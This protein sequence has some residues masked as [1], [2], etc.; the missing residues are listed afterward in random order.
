MPNRNI[1][2]TIVAAAVVVI[3]LVIGANAHFFKGQANTIATVPL[4][5]D[6]ADNPIVRENTQIGTSDWKIPAGQDATTEIQ[7][8]VSA[9]SVAPGQNI[10]FYVSTQQAG[11][12]YTLFVYRLGWYMGKG[13]RQMMAAHGVGEAQG[14]FDEANSKLVDC[15]TCYVDHNTGLVEARW[16]PSYSLTIP[17]DWT[18]GVYLVKLVDANNKQTY[19]SFDVLGN[20]NSTYVVVTADTTYAAYNDWGGYSLYDYNSPHGRASH[21]S[22]LRP[23]TQQDGSDQV[24]VFEADAIHWLEQ[25]GYNLSYISSVDLHTH[26]E[27]LLKHK[28]YI[29]LGHDEYWTKEM[30]DGVD[31]ARDHGVGLAFLEA[32]ASYWQMRFEPSTSGQPD[33]TLVCYKVQSDNH[34][35]ARDPLYGKDNSRVT[36]MWRDPVVN[37]PENELIGI[38]FSDITHKQK[39]YPWIVDPGAKSSFMSGTNLTPGESYGCG[40]VG[41]EWDK[42]FNNGSTPKNLQVLATSPTIND[43]GQKDSSNTT[44]YFAPSGAMVFASGSVYWAAGLD[45]YRY[46]TDS[47]CPGQASTIS[48]MQKLLSNVMDGLIV[49]H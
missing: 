37:R 45:T 21:V 4:G 5:S 42:I 47:H 27:A 38:M 1:I 41:Y 14:Y 6:S 26:P 17:N 46:E 19:T 25:Q 49:H 20:T 8:Y 16:K 12:R 13:A 34:D 11:T 15:T 9:R 43:D 39:G 24:L 33:E 29:S 10:T 23:S 48:G 22:F 36:G 2:A 32:D 40:L 3:A 35:L 31:S 30:R 28:A 44:I 18:S 7:A